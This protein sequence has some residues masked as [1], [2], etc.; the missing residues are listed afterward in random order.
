MRVIRWED[1][2]AVEGFEPA[3]LGLLFRCSTDRAIRSLLSQSFKSKSVLF[4]G[5]QL[6]EQAIL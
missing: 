6:F 5:T 4:I 2:T 1:C 3:I